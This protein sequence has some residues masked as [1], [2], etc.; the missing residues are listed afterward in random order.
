MRT[1]K[2][3]YVRGTEVTLD[4]G[5][6]EPVVVWVQKL[7]PVEH[8][9]SVDKAG[10]L[11]ARIL[12]ISKDPDNED[13]QTIVNQVLDAEP[14][15]L[16]DL[17]CMVERARIAQMVSAEIADNAEWKDENYLTGLIQSWQDEFEV[18]HKEDPEDEEAARVHS[19]LARFDQKV[20]DE[21][22]HRIEVFKDGL[23]TMSLQE[24]QDMAIDHN[25][26]LT[27]DLAWNNEYTH[28]ALFHAVRHSDDRKKRVFGTRKDLD[29]LQVP[30]FTALRDA[31]TSMT[32]D[33]MEG[34]DSAATPPS[35]PTSEQP[36]S[37]AA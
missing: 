19:E 29:E 8:K 24:L 6:G 12:T 37:E 13:Y 1:L 3:L 23:E 18:K 15:E 35:S 9:T 30:V 7:N 25:V 14:S 33:V 4:D 21:T 32:V 20:A 17:H 27:A 11:R 2:D 5:Q 26:K 31:L 22:D 36:D 34:K 10:A 16:I 28:W